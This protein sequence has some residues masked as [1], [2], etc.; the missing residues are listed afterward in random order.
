MIRVAC[1]QGDFTWA[2]T[3]HARP[4]ASSYGRIITAKTLKY[5]SA[6]EA[7]KAEL[8]AEWALG[9]PLKPLDMTTGWMERGAEMEAE[10]RRWY[11]FERDVDVEQVGF[12][13][14]SDERTG[15]SPDGLVGRE[16]VLEVKCLGAAGHMKALLEGAPD[17]WTAQVQGYLYLTDRP[18]ADLCLY[19]PTLPRL[20]HRVERDDKFI[21][22]LHGHLGR[23]LSELDEGKR[24]L[25]EMGLVPPLGAILPPEKGAAVDTREELDSGA[26]DAL[27][28]GV[29]PDP[30][31]MNE[32]EIGSLGD[33]LPEAVAKG[34]ITEERAQEIRQLVVAGNFV[35]ARKSWVQICDAMYPKKAS[36]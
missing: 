27:R 18:W 28:N 35:E 15:G 33:V 16:G 23:F 8:L 29:E 32:D 14:R 24:K 19:H 12:I 13:L 10:A 26:A 11:S 22:A 36:A 31:E 4:T 25:I 7:F 34:V 2:Y 5:A 9:V 17:D 20:I 6:A 3:R 30:F 21:T 1:E